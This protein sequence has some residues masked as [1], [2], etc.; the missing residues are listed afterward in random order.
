MRKFLSLLLTL[1][2]VFSLAVTVNAEETVVTSAPAAEEDLTGS[3]IILHTNDVHGQIDRYAQVAALKQTYEKMGAYVLLFDAGDYIQGDTTVS[4][5]EG[6]TAIELMNLVGYDAAALGNHECDYCY[7]NLVKLS[8]EAEFPILSANTL[9]EGKVAFQDHVTFT[10]PDG[11]K[12]GVFGL[13]TPETATK[14]HPAKIKGVTFPAGEEMFKLAQA[15]VDAL[16]AD[17]CDVI[18]CLGHLGIDNESVGNRSIDL[19]EKVSGIDVF[20]DAHSH[21]TL[22]DILAVTGN[23]GKVGD[24][25]LTSTG[26]KLA[27]IGCVVIK[28][29]AAVTMNLPYE[30]LIT[31]PDATV[32]AKAAEIAAQIEAD[33]GTPFAKSL[34]DLNGA[35][36]P[37]GN[38]D[39]ETNNGDLITDAILWYATKDG[40]LDVDNDHVIALTNGGGIRAPIKAG[41]ITKKDINTVLPFGN[42][43]A[44]IYVTG[45]E[46][47]EALEASTYCTPDAVG[48]F[49]QVSGINFTIDT[50][51]AYDAGDLYPG[52]T[53]HAPKSINRVTIESIN[54]KAFDP[55]AKYAVVTNDFTAAGGDTYYAFSVATVMNTGVPMDQ[56]LMDYIT[57]QLGGVVGEQYAAPQG[58]ITI[59]AAPVVEPE[60]QPEPT[61]APSGDT[62]TVVAGDCL[63]NIAYKL[64]GSGAQFTKLA[65]ANKIADPYIIY[66]GQILTVP[67]K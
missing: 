18:V 1:A 55:A 33:Y 62:Y 48:G 57:T 6:A 58:R 61:P 47:L 3:I 40:G 64:Y 34:V 44:V 39:S 66:V 52:S 7:E 25:L 26:T 60:P 11:T 45:A 56:A 17:K 22:E 15:Q 35:K 27:N 30:E 59:K 63:W 67:A 65:E 2:M 42:T 14:A 28:D 20:I 9:Y 19:L 12:I 29:G 24:T 32:A 38:R 23:T 8:K 5:S 53:Y 41:D 13:E 31:T 36:A 16:K 10:A 51:K 4:L 46:L 37:N 49:P 43:V 50:T 21:S 54:G